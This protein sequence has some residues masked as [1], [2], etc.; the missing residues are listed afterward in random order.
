[1]AEMF[2]YTDNFNQDISMWN[3]SK[4][5]R[6]DSMFFSSYAFNQNISTWDTSKVTQMNGMF[7]AAQ[8]FNQNLSGWTVNPNVAYCNSFRGNV[9]AYTLPIPNFTSCN[10]N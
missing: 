7:W 2:N 5:T 4:V 8:A 9:P 3:T 1:M 10:P 6:M